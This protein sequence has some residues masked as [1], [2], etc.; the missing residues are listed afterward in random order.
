[1]R[2]D[3]AAS[4]E[5]ITWTLKRAAHNIEHHVTVLLANHDLS[6]VQLGVLAQLAT[7]GPLTRAELARLTLTTPQSMA[8]V[9]DGMV[10]KGL[11][12][13]VGPRGTGRGKPNPLRLTAEGDATLETVWPPFQEANSAAALGLTSSEASVLN[14]LLH[15]LRVL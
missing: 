10:A 2:L 7:E 15:R 13:F 1:M 9:I 8:G 12:E 3:P 11:I 6:P 14:A 4:D 5:A